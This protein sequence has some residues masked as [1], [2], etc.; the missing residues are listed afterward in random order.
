MPGNIRES[1]LVLTLPYNLDPMV[2]NIR[3]LCLNEDLNSL[4][5]YVFGLRRGNS[6][7]FGDELKV[8]IQEKIPI[9]L[10]VGVKVPSIPLPKIDGAL[11]VEI[12]GLKIEPLVIHLNLHIKIPKVECI[13]ELSSEIE[14]RIVKIMIKKKNKK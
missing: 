2:L 4:P 12:C 7:E 11:V 9:K 13:R 5:E 6:N 1:E 10:I 8:R 14:D 3:A